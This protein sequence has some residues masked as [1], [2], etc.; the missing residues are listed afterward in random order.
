M[1]LAVWAPPPE[2]VH[3][4]GASQTPHLSLWGFPMETP[5]GPSRSSVKNTALG[6]IV[7]SLEH[8]RCT[9]RVHDTIIEEVLWDV[10]CRAPPLGWDQRANAR[11]RDPAGIVS[12]P[13]TTPQLVFDIHYG[14]LRSF[15]S[16][17]FHA[18]EL[19]LGS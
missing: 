16:Y 12:L 1:P 15:P 7:T 6:A 4:V 13:M 9:A 18:F 10:A 2:R 19:G 17:A 5:E 3:K 11:M 8:P 14:G